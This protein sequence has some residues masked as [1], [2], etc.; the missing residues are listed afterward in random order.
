MVL[1]VW[2][3]MPGLP[4]LP[5]SNTQPPAT[6]TLD[7]A[8]DFLGDPTCDET[9]CNLFD[10]LCLID[11]ALG[12]ESCLD[13]PCPGG[14]LQAGCPIQQCSFYTIDCQEVEFCATCGDG[15][16]DL[17]ETC[18]SSYCRDAVCTADCGPLYCPLDCSP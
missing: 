10:I 15:I 9:V 16:C 14:S 18:T 5:A 3:V 6:T 8:C 12:R 2:I 17:I 13:T 7:L 4:A 1:F 11:C